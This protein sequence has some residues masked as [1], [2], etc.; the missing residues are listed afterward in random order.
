MRVNAQGWKS[1][2]LAAAGSKLLCVCL[3]RVE[4]NRNGG[5]IE[6]E[7]KKK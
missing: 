3:C 6:N 2:V 7:K 4:K 5:C 1:G